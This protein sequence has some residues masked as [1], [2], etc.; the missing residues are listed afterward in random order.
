[1]TDDLGNGIAATVTYSTGHHGLV[2]VVGESHYQD[3]LR[4]L[5]SRIGS[6]GVFTARLVPEPLNPHDA[7][8]VAVCVEGD[9]G[10]VGYLARGVAKSYHAPLARR[11]E[12]VT[13]PARLTGVD[14]VTIGVVLDFEEVREALGLPR[15]SVDQGDIDYDASDEYHRL[16]RANRSFVNET[17]PMERS[18]PAEAVARYQR[19]LAT[20]LECRE[21]ARAKRLEVYGFA[22]N[23]T[24]AIPIDRLTRCLVNA[25]RLDEA[26]KELDKFIE[27]FPH[28]R[29][30][31][32]LKAARKRVDTARSGATRT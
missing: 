10:T 20:L 17:R 15:V 1:L 14:N 6:G 22:L 11:S 30:M 25:G 5:A 16:N 31:T 21:L 3:V 2:Q 8:A 28:A 18:D 24:D 12:P 13:C 26:A 19:A 29:D 32:L 23:Q 27:E 4:A 7:N 9:L